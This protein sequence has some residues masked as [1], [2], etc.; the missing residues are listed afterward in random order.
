MRGGYVEGGELTIEGKY[1]RNKGV[2]TR[3]EGGGV[4][5]EGEDRAVGGGEG[6]WTATCWKD[7]DLNRL[8][9]GGAKEVGSFNPLMGS[10]FIPSHPPP[11]P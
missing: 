10:V 11:P 1:E 7:S 5:G 3:E 2:S 9:G 6:V 8:H 4:M